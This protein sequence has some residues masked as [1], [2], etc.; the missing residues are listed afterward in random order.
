[1]TANFNIDTIRFLTEQTMARPSR[2]NLKQE[3]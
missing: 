3:L 1:M 2:R